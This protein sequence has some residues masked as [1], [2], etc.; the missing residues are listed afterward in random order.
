MQIKEL[1][2]IIRRRTTREITNQCNK[3]GKD[4]TKLT[5][6]PQDICVNKSEAI[7]S[8][9]CIQNHDKQL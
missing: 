7:E 5:G 4:S 9:L 1:T 6:I 2:K 3:E 8:L